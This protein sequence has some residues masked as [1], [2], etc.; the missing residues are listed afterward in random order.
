VRKNEPREGKKVVKKNGRVAVVL[1]VSG[2]MGFID[3]FTLGEKLCKCDQFKLGNRCQ[4][5]LLQ[6]LSEKYEEV[7]FLTD[8]FIE[9][10]WEVILASNVKV[11][12]LNFMR[13]VL[14]VT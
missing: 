7:L 1:D 4:T 14:E 3:L 5:S 12:K 6:E 9:P 8:G 2:S 10:S 13:G 11:V